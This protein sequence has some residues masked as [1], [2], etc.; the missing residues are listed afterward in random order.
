MRLRSRFSDKTPWKSC[1]I[2][3]A[4]F[5]PL[6][7][8]T[9]ALLGSGRQPS[10]LGSI[11][12]SLP[13]TSSMFKPEKRISSCMAFNG[14]GEKGEE[15]LEEGA[16]GKKGIYG[17]DEEVVQREI[18]GAPFRK[19][20][21]IL[22]GVFAFSSLGLGILSLAGMAG[23]EQAKELSEAAPNPLLDLGV[24]ATTYYLWVEEVKTKRSALKLVE[25][26]IQRES[27]VPNRQAR[28]QRKLGKEAKKPAKTASPIN[29]AGATGVAG[30]EKS[31]ASGT[32]TGARAGATKEG[33]RENPGVEPKEGGIL[34][35]VRQ[36]LDDANQLGYAQA[37]VLNQNL[38][39]R[40]ILP[41]INQ[42]NATTSVGSADDMRDNGALAETPAEEVTEVDAHPPAAV[43]GV[44]DSAAAVTGGL[45]VNPGASK[46][47]RAKKTK[48]TKRRRAKP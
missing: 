3:V 10:K 6:A 38:E 26:Q 8:N 42:K 30:R 44:A 2:A 20:R 4:F 1:L 25:K 22:L 43:P 27:Q 32:G 34:D 9:L 37:M 48:N 11:G 31:R 24:L 18:E 14:G 12:R 17:F 41:P 15:G 28:R 23:V 33:P 40:G 39:E 47:M 29:P 46:E 35:G 45:S 7:Q 13:R 5:L 16:Q 36:M 21:L 19:F